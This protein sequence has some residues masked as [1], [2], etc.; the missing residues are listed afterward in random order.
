MNNNQTPTQNEAND[1][2]I[3]SNDVFVGFEP[4]NLL[5][6]VLKERGEILIQANGRSMY[7]TI[8]KGDRIL[9]KTCEKT[10]VKMGDIV[11][12]RFGRQFCLHR[13]VKD[14]PLLTK[15]DALDQVDPPIE[16]VYGHVLEIQKTFFSRI[17][18]WKIFFAKRIGKEGSNL[19]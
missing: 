2:L 15:G 10:Q 1:S 18:R 11:F 8:V 17:R 6:E 16:E 3:G 9:L 4:S 13:V 7:P 5:A 12:A 19:P 14:F